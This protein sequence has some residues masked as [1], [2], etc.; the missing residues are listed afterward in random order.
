MSMIPFHKPGAKRVDLDGNQRMTEDL[1]SG[2]AS[3]AGATNSV[4]APEQEVKQA[5]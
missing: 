1:E 2:N 4:I 3:T 5:A